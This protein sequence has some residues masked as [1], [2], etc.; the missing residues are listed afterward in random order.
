MD[1][2]SSRLDVSYFA[3]WQRAD[4]DL[5]LHV[6]AGLPRDFTGGRWQL[7]DGQGV[8]H[9]SAAGR[10][11]SMA[12]ESPFRMM[13]TGEALLVHLLSL[14]ESHGE[15]E[16]S[17]SILIHDGDLFQ[18]GPAIECCGAIESLVDLNADEDGP[19]GAEWSPVIVTVDRASRVSATLACS[20]EAG[21][22]QLRLLECDGA[23]GEVRMRWNVPVADP[24]F[25]HEGAVTRVQ[26][27]P[28]QLLVLSAR[29]A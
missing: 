21:T 25:R 24:S 29:R 17:F 12:I 22:I 14:R 10:G 5:N 13:T 16:R 26:I 6:D 19:A 3:A 11:I 28:Q 7:I 23:P 18:A 4:A 27:R 2:G 20:A 15:V 8:I 1:A 9:L